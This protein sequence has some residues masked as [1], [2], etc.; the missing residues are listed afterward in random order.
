VVIEFLGHVRMREVQ[1]H[2]GQA[3]PPDPQRV[4]LPSKDRVGASV[5]VAAPGL[6]QGAL[7]LGLGLVTTLLGDLRAV[8]DWTTDAV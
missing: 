2:A 6:A 4:M 7:T 1:A 5:E 8:T 3:Q